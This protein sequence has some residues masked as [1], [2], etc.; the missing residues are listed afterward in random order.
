MKRY[1]VYVLL[2]MAQLASAEFIEN[3]WVY[4]KNMA[5]DDALRVED[6]DFAAV[7]GAADDYK[8][9]WMFVTSSNNSN[10]FRVVNRWAEDNGEE[11]TWLWINKG[12][13]G[14]VTN[15]VQLNNLTGSLA[16]WTFSSVTVDTTVAY[17][18]QTPNGSVKN[19]DGQTVDTLWAETSGSVI[20]MNNV[21]GNKA[22]WIIEPVSGDVAP[23]V[24]EIAYETDTILVSS[25]N[26]SPNASNTLYTVSILTDTNWTAVG[27]AITGVTATNWVVEPSADVAFF[28][29]ES[30]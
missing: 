5:L 21:S 27:S 28:K 14:G 4:I 20:Q 18:I 30:E 29:L 13:D 11:E 12:D 22:K 16:E 24:L 26:L 3:Q 1:M 17:Y 8:A 6:A 15:T 25:A 9:Q 23:A 7:L 2:F 19:A 10:A